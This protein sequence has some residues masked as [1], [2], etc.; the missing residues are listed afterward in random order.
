MQAIELW[1]GW[2]RLRHR[3]GQILDFA[4]CRIGMVLL[5][6]DD[7]CASRPRNRACSPSPI[8]CGLHSQFFV[9]AGGLMSYGID[10]VDTFRLA[11]AYVDQHLTRSTSPPTC[12]LQAPT[13]L[14]NGRQPRS[15]R[16]SLT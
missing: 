6:S 13:R 3:T 11:A 16:K 9:V 14:W 12:R 8:A 7:D 5:P 10:Q 15:P 2:E 1:L 4:E